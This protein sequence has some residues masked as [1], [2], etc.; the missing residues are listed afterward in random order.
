MQQQLRIGIIGYGK[1]GRAIEQIARGR[2]HSISVVIDGPEQSGKITE[3]KDKVDAYVEFTS[4]ESAFTNIS[5]CISAGVPVVSGSTGWMD[6][7]DEIAEQVTKYEGAFFYASNFSVG[8][9]L[10]MKT[11]EFLSQ[12]MND[13]TEYD[14][15]VEEAAHVQDVSPTILTDFTDKYPMYDQY[16]FLVSSPYISYQ[17]YIN[18]DIYT[19]S[20]CVYVI[21]LT[22][23]SNPMN[24]YLLQSL[25]EK[26]EMSTYPK[27]IN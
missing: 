5:A 1:M 19:D 6:R 11:A 4:G 7:Y 24:L 18:M 26:P 23:I 10:F 9:F 22:M 21:Y 2:G 17:A 20:E 8:V 16:D 27:N 12:L 25:K 14:V 13:Q 15:L 3:Y